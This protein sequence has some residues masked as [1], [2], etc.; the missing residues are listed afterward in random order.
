[1]VICIVAL[2]VF[3]VMGI[4]SAKYRRLAKEA[5]RCAAKM[6]TFRPCDVGLETR[7]KTKVTSK[8]MR[9]PTMARFFY[10]HFKTLSIIFTVAFF[11]SIAGVI[12]GIYNYAAFGNCNGPQSDGFCIYNAASQLITMSP[13]D[14]VIGSHPIRGNP[15]ANLTIIE[16]AC[17]QCR[18]SKAAEPTVEQLL[19]DYSGRVNLAF[20]FFPLPQ[21]LHGRMAATAAYCAGEQGKFWEYHDLLFQLQDSFSNNETDVQ[22][23]ATIDGAAQQVGLNMTQFNACIDSDRAKQKV[24]SDIDLGNRLGIA[25]T[26][27]FFIGGDKITGPQPYSEFQSAIERNLKAI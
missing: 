18:Y 26:P 21:H 20:F 7:I 23:I 5:L 8:L 2:V 25:G 3:S 4:W 17:L 6:I 11:L 19:N 10:K 12:Y 16:F 9:V 15:N 27:T 13:R 14:I 24:Q 22:A 1:M